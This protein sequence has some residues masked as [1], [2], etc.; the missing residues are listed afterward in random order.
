MKSVVVTGASTG[1]GKGTAKVLL[2]NGF[3]VFGSV[4]KEADG[5]ALQAEFGENFTPLIFDV[6]DETAV[7]AGAAIVAEAIGQE[8]LSGLVN[9]AG[10]AVGGPLALL[11]LA[12]FRYQIEVNVLGVFSVTQAF[13]PL[14]GTD[15]TRK[16]A[17]G[18]VVN[19]SSVAGKMSA[20]FLGPYTASKHALE[21]MSTSLRRELMLY[22]IDVVIIGPGAVATPIWDKA[23][24]ADPTPY[25]KSDYADALSKFRDYIMKVGPAGDPPE[26]IGR[27][28]HEALTTS[29]PKWR[30][31][32]V[33]RKLVNWTLPRLLPARR[34]D[35]F[36][37]RQLGLTD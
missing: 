2:D 22:G 19:I 26:K 12:E 37:A 16:G 14:L 33:H 4:R 32:P 11:P 5:A 8:K 28:V 36:F 31:A 25:M 20:P 15:R 21:A 17:P 27:C 3:R 18:R 24:E 30:Y 6:T 35:K 1:I 34:V 7:R 13:L 10:V 23:K 9:N 29:P